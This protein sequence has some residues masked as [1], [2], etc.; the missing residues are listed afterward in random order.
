MKTVGE[1]LK[2]AR[3]KKKLTFTQLKKA[4]KIPAKTLKALEKNQF[5]RL[6]S[7]TYIAGFIKNYSQALGLDSK[8]TLSVFRRDYQNQAGKKILPQGLAKPLNQSFTLN[9]F[10]RNIISIALVVIVFFG[11][12]AF[13]LF[14][15]NAPPK[16]ILT[17]PKNT[18]TTTSP[19]LIKGQTDQDTTLTL[20]GKTIN[21]EPD[22][23]FTTVFNGPPG[24][25]QLKLMAIS[26]RNKSTQ[27]TRYVIITE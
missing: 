18:I 22:G 14:K 27:L 23:S 5:S 24:T 21:L 4:T 16:L 20:N 13:S 10:T 25:H 9:P 3:L 2:K 8:K 19:V 6:P 17:Q 7:Q 26:R 15:L 11:L 12:I 1:L